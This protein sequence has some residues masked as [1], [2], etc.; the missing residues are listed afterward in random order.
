MGAND[1]TLGIK[2]TADG[3]GLVGEVKLSRDELDRLGQSTRNYNSE[4]ARLNQQNKSLAASF[5]ETAVELA[6]YYSAYKLLEQLKD[7]TMLAARVDTLNVS[8]NAVGKNL[9]YTGAQ[10]REYVKDVQTM[11]IA[12]VEAQ[13]TIM[14]MMQAQLDLNKATQ[15]ARVAQDAAVIG[16]M[17]SSQALEAMLHGITTLQPEVL[18]NLGITVNLENEYQKFAQT[19]HRT[20]S[21]LSMQEKQQV[22]LNAVLR[23]GE[24]IAGVYGDAMGSVGK[25]ISSL[26]RYISDVSERV[27]NLFTPALSVAVIA[28]TEALKDSRN[29]L[30]AFAKD[31]SAQAFAEKFAFGMAAA[32]DVLGSFK[33]GMKVTLVAVNMAV[34]DLATAVML[35]F[36]VPVDAVAAILQELF[37]LAKKPLQ[38]AA[39]NGSTTAKSMLDSLNNVTLATDYSKRIVQENARLQ[40]EANKVLENSTAGFQTTDKLTEI[41]LKNADKVHV[42]AVTEKA[43]MDELKGH[44]DFYYNFFQEKK[45]TAEAYSSTIAA[46]LKNSIWGDNHRY[47]KEPPGSA[48][49]DTAAESAIKHANDFIK[50]LKLQ[51]AQLGLDEAQKK[52]VEAATISLTVKSA[53]LRMEIMQA[54]GAFAAHYAA[55]QSAIEAE[56]KNAAAIDALIKKYDEQEMAKSDA[57]KSTNDYVLSL[58]AGND[59]RDLEIGLMG[60]SEAA[61]NIAIGQYQIEKELQA[62]ILKIKMAT[63]D[64]DTRS[65][66]IATASAAASAAKENL[67]GYIQINE[68]MRE[69]N[70]LW[71]TVEK[72][73]KDAFVHLFS[74]GKSAAEG[75]GKAIKASVIDL[76]YQLTARKWIINIGTSLAGSLGISGG[77]SG[78]GSI[79]NLASSAYSILGS[80]TGIG[81]QVGS[82]L[83]G[84]GAATASTLAAST[85]GGGMA[86]GGSQAAM[87]AGQ[88]GVF[89]AEG[90]AAT[91]AAGG[92]EAGGIAS[93]LAAIPGWGWA[94]GAGLLLAGSSGLFGGGGGP[95]TEWYG[96][97]NASAFPGHDGPNG[98]RDTNR[99]AQVDALAA[100][101]V[102]SYASTV[103]R[104]GG[105]AA[106][107]KL[108]LSGDSD[109]NGTAPDSVGY[110]MT[111]NGGQ[112]YQGYQNFGKG[113]GQQHLPEIIN[114]ALL[115]AFQATDMGPVANAIVA[116]LDPQTITTDLLN[117]TAAALGGAADLFGA[118]SSP[119]QT[120][121][122][123]ARSSS[124]SLAAK[125]TDAG[126]AGSVSA[127]SIKQA[128]AALDL[129]STASQQA[130]RDMLALVAGVK[131]YETQLLGMIG[132][133]K[134]SLAS[135]LL[136]AMRNSPDAAAAGETFAQNVVSGIEN[137]MLGDLASQVSDIVTSG[138][139]T[140][141]LNALLTGQSVSE[142]LSQANMDAV[143]KQATAT[144]TAFGQIWSNPDFIAAMEK[145]RATVSST[146]ATSLSG[147]PMGGGG[148]QQAEKD[149]AD[150]VATAKANLVDAYK[151]E[152]D[153]Q[154]QL[155]DKMRGYVTSLRN[156]R[157]SLLLGD[158]SPLGNQA[159]YDE[160][161]RQWE[162]ISR[163]AALGDTAAIEQQQGAGQAFLEASRAYNASSEAYVRDFESVRA[164]LARTESVAERQAR[165]A[166][167]AAATARSQLDALGDI[168]RSVLT[169]PDAIRALA[170]A[171]AQQ[172]SLTERDKNGIWTSTGGATYDANTGMI[173]GTSG[174]SMF[175][176]AA[177]GWVNDQLAAGNPMLVYQTLKNE[178]VSLNSANVMMGWAPGT[179]ETWALQHG[180]PTFAAGGGASSGLYIAGE[181]GPELIEGMAATRIYPADQTSMIER[182]LNS[183][184]ANDALIG[185]I[186]ELR[187]QVASADRDRARLAALLE[188]L[189]DAVDTGTEQTSSDLRGMKQH[190]SHVMSR[191]AA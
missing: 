149:A 137:A 54:A 11:G 2:L 22:A 37:N 111:L 87:L 108:R 154:Q 39:D 138:I 175:K 177:V 76:L 114:R 107:M 157:Q 139:I 165:I 79:F 100:G 121:I 110:A 6:K 146:T 161:R 67:A 105:N 8:L 116:G 3:K 115:T 103:A 96:G 21:S 142:A 9:G 144:A 97:Q 134:E 180:L 33:E 153:A 17:N 150:S 182:R 42:A 72:T 117:Q 84:N 167:D 113:E 32:I 178:G 64:E 28:Y 83:A 52:A 109:P 189:I 81:Y 94:L 23:E 90:A 25:Q 36:T 71:S 78:S 45:L 183:P 191:M 49:K 56:K 48:A 123:A 131:T 38:W 170:L 5:R 74:E 57:I 179:A 60:Q 75:I 124:D 43:A 145:I 88:T 143:I 104:F 133:T 55:Q 14:R 44:V 136:D 112:L 164:G 160:A 102:S 10:V 15:L 70:N 188:R 20:A 176:T 16:N 77:S 156:Y 24:K 47:N 186:N 65:E 61:R 92:I 66:Q 13:T 171:L 41:L 53:A 140:P 27:G 126:I 141:A 63:T 106:A 168:N 62:Q 152:L 125:F 93:G 162:D 169:I 122:A 184:A 7:A 34:N 12:H 185:E 120:A 68:Q 89:G 174:A 130:A 82:F 127:G 151:R 50:Q 31:G 166:A 86:F 1:I 69:W 159:K 19:T 91:M 135:N 95:K 98:L 129:T 187:R 46:L 155:A 181:R 147:A 29:E 148:Y 128:V 26:P 118:P 18:R 132:F 99:S 85:Y 51:D 73:G 30:D 190:L 58:Q 40:A 173:T 158:L 172:S 35:A 59:Q 163:R 101:G 119:L 80:G 4:A